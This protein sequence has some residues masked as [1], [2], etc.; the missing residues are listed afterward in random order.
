MWNPRHLSK[1]AGLLAAGA[2]VVVGAG[3]AHGSGVQPTLYVNYTMGCTFSITDDSGKAVTAIAPGA[4]QVL[5]ASPADFGAIDLSGVNDLMACK[6]SVHFQLTGPGVSLSTTL[7]DG[8]NDQALLQGSFQPSGTYVAQDMTPGATA[9]VSFSTTAT[10]T[11]VTPSV[12][13]TTTGS[14]KAIPTSG[15]QPTAATGPASALPLRGVLNAT[16]SPT[17]KVALKLDGKP[18]DTLKPGRYVIAVVDQSTKSGFVVQE[19]HKLATAVT[20]ARFTGKRSAAV[21][22][23][24]GQWVFYPSVP[25]TK[26]H[27]SVTS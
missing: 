15:P 10:G 3:L 5:V 25:G 27:F 18:V 14:G 2:L 12:P 16:L 23:T 6:G 22:L 21:A 7:D 13:Y 1:A 20:S 8:D 24:K 11:P 9:R 19:L 26:T 4:Y 17:G